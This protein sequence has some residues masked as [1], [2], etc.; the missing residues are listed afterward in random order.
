MESTGDDVRA[1]ARALFDAAEYDDSLQAALD[2]L[3]A[4][5]DDVELLVLAGRAEVELDAPD[6]VAHLRRATELAPDN[7]NAWHH[8][9][10]ALATDG[11]TDEADA[12]FRRTVELAPGDQVALSHLGHTALAS[13]RSA[14]GVGYLARAADIAH[15]ASTAAISLVDMYR[16]FGR[17]AEALTQARRIADNAPDDVLTRLDVAELSLT[18]GELDDA[19]SAFERLREL[20]DVPGHE[21]Y[22]L[23]GMIR[24]EIQREQ[25]P[26][27][28]E[29]AN[30]LAAIEPHGLSTELS[31]FLHAQ[32]GEPTETPAPTRAEIEAALAASLVEYRR[33]LGDDRRISAGD[34]VD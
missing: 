14:E 18:V 5:P 1:R 12:A 20:D 32:A 23:H 3:S 22:P 2:G 13:G 19:Y 6:A 28:A 31:A 25:W 26:L 16:S 33:M 15:G 21:A 30:Q 17:N 34:R 29:L 24:V 9:G 4:T 27:A 7:A 11:R 10:E 8:L